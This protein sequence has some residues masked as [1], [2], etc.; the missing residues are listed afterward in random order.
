MNRYIHT[1]KLKYADIHRG[2]ALNDGLNNHL[3]KTGTVNIQSSYDAETAAVHLLNY[4]ER[5]NTSND[6][7]ALPRQ[8]TKI[9]GVV[10]Y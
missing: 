10:Q 5:N 1:Y 8:T 3:S 4:L 9:I 7:L 2:S 6:H